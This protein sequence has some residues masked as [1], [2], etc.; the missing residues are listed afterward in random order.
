[1]N[2][3][4]QTIKQAVAEE[5][6]VTVHMINSS[7]RARHIARPRMIAMY[8]AA[9]TTTKSLPEIGRFFGK[10][11]HTTVMHA[12]RVVRELL[13]S[14]IKLRM[15]VEVLK[16]SLRTHGATA[17]EDLEPLV[18]AF[19]QSLR[20]MLLLRARHNPQRMLSLLNA[21]FKRSEHESLS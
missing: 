15:R 7:R 9:E 18:D 21:F 16:A 1:V 11:D 17:E 10:R 5:F 19:L 12:L 14:D 8:L 20:E 3:A 2:L 4:L 13:A 6:G